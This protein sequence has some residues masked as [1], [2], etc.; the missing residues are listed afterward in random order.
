MTTDAT[1]VD[2]AIAW[3]LRQDSMAA[4]DWPAFIAWLED[5]AHAAAFDLVARTDRLLAEVRFPAVEPLLVA[6]NDDAPAARRWWW[7]AGGTGIAAALALAVLPLP[8]ATGGGQ[9]YATRDGG[10]RTVAL[11]DGSEIAMNGGTAITVDR[12]GRSAQLDR[13]EVMLRVAHNPA[14]PFVLRAGDQTIRDLG[15][16]FDVALTGRTLVIAV[17]DGSVGLQGTDRSVVLQR[18]DALTIDRRTGAAL[19]AAVAPATVGGWQA[20]VLSFDGVPL[21][22][23]AAALQRRLGTQ[24]TMAGDLSLRPFTGILRLSGTAERDVPHLAGLIG[25]TWRRDGKRWVL[26][27]DNRTPR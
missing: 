22:D 19:R 25:A 13:G 3:Q 9:V 15:T 6:A 12:G 20:G 18:G 4:S 1:I 17:A 11:A 26:S 23:V 14:A 5:N 21:D 27:E 24:V 16:R 8:V 7:A 10:H 2:Q